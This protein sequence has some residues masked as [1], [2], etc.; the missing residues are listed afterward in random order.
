MKRISRGFRKKGKAICSL[1]LAI[2]LAITGVPFFPGMDE[3]VVYADTTV[4]LDPSRI[5]TVY[6]GQSNIMFGYDDLTHDTIIS[7]LEESYV[8]DSNSYDPN[9]EHTVTWDGKINGVPA[10]EGSYT[11]QVEPQG[12][13]AKYAKEETIE[14]SNPKPPAP[15]YLEVVPDTTSD[16]H[17][18]RGIAEKGTEV[19]LEISY[20]IRDGYEQVPGETVTINNI[21]VRDGRQWSALR[22][23]Q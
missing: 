13:F 6:G 1:F 17:I 7:I 5:N 18:I 12:E 22:N 10:T 4:K 15:K 14:V 19:T 23:N 9:I 3:N 2:V 21:G 16:S 20:T 11:I 8:I